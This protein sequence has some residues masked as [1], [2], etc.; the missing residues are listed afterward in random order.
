M[1]E[2]THVTKKTFCYTIAFSIRSGSNLLCDLLARNGAG[3]PTEYFQNPFGVTNK[4]WYDTLDVPP[5]DFPTF[6]TRLVATRAQNGIF[7]SK[8]TWFQKNGL[9]KTLARV[10]EPGISTLED[11][12]PR[13]QWVFLRRRD[14]FAQAV[15]AWLAQQSGR[16]LSERARETAPPAIEYDFRGIQT[17]LETILVEEHLWEDYF[18]RA[19]VQPI[20]L[21]YEDLVQDRAGVLLDLLRQLFPLAGVKPPDPATLM[22]ESSF[23]KQGNSH[24]DTMKRLFMQDL[25][26]IQ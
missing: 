8:V 1:N 19:G 9:L 7:G 18:A 14:R 21:W 16:W 17:F 20:S 3:Y 25:Y 12:F 10:F 5:D 2:L 11:V 4:H 6:M 13:H 15:S 26:R 22:V 23:R 24:S